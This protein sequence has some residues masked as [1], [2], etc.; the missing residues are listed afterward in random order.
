MAFGF[1]DIL[2]LIGGLGL[3][4]Y[5][6]KMM[7][8]GLE[9]VAGSRLKKLLAVLTSNRLLAVLVGLAV[10]AV[11]QSSSATTVMIIGFV[12]AGLMNLAQ[13][14]G[15]IMGAN[16]G[17]TVTSQLIA[18]KVG[19][20]TLTDLAPIAVGIGVG[21]IMFCKKPTIKH[22]GQVVAGFGIL[23]M[24]MDTMSTAME[25][26]QQVPEFVNLL[27]QFQNPFIGILVGAL[28][29]AIIQ[30]SSA[31]VGILQA[32][33]MQGLIGLD[34]AI[35]V[36]F[37]QNIGTCVTALLSS[38]GT[39]KTAKR[40]AIV[41]LLFNVAGTII[42]VPLAMFLPFVDWMQAITGNIPQQIANTHIIFNLVSTAVLLPA[43]PLLVKAANFIIPGKDKAFE[44]MQLQ[45]LDERILATPPI[46]VAQVI[47]ESERMA[48]LARQEFHDSIEYFFKPNSEL[49]EKVTANK[50]VLD[51]LNKEITSYLIKT[52]ALELP[53]SDSKAV[54]A[55]FHTINDFQ[56]IGDHAENIVEAGQAMQEGKL[57]LSENAVNEMKEM[58]L[59][60]EVLLD[61]A[62]HMFRTRVY[63]EELAAAINRS[64]EEVDQC[65]E[66]F[67][68]NHIRR[69]TKHKCTPEQ[70]VVFL[71]ILGDLERVADH[72]T[73]IAFSLSNQ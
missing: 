65:T 67:R 72:A 38:I 42:F 28:F 44:P 43:A 7:G 18:F 5:G 9:L 29:T 73:N 47:K 33:A 54:G 58:S 3:F 26:L 16:I 1:G 25:P 71:D 21:L 15:V 8:D 6:M 11:I 53:A 2:M 56:R 23:F 48:V 20:F 4:L 36:L 49:L 61:E 46:A 66:E 17:T 63:D 57:S 59:R 62:L 37:G 10:T 51:Y 13:A 55:L 69:L 68:N 60:V 27:T 19:D 14:V 34:G 52:S 30:S 45:Y 22:V 50:Q 24:G 31:S 40:A 35:F 32:L 12:N 39:T 64:E 41:H 70:G